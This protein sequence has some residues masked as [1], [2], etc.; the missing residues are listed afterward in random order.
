MTDRTAIVTTLARTG[1]AEAVEPLIGVARSGV[2]S[3]EERALALAALGR[4]AEPDPL[5]WWCVYARGL[6]D[7][8]APPT[9]A[10]LFDVP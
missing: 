2:R 7:T 3:I 5:P 8:A 1:D 6:H 9:L 10:T 4:I